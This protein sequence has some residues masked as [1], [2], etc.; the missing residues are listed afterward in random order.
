MSDWPHTL[1][2]DRTAYA[3]WLLAAGCHHHYIFHA[4][5]ISVVL[6]VMLAMPMRLVLELMLEVR[7][8]PKL[9]IAQLLRALQVSSREPPINGATGQPISTGQRM[10]QHARPQMR[11]WFGRSWARLTGQ[12]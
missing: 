1:A 11:V 10:N 9:Q 3:L 12:G 2:A 6:P 8:M 5:K 7:R 4:S